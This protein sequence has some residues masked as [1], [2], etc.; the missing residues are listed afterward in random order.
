MNHKLLPILAS[1]ACALVL[2]ACRE[3]TSPPNAGRLNVILINIDT[4]RAD[5]LGCYGYVLPTSPVID[6]LASEGGLFTDA[7][8]NSS[9]T[10]ES[11]SAL[12][13]GMLPSHAG[14]AGWDAHPSNASPRRGRSS[15]PR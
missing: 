12:F 14:A 13:S 11:V 4:L 8:A 5:H 2:A 6:R 1:V 3:S 9:Y 7:A 10:R 15:A